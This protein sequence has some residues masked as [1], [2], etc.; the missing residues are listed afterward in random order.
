MTTVTNVSASNG[1]IKLTNN[2]SIEDA[3]SVFN[4]VKQELV[5]QIHAL[6]D[7][8]RKITKSENVDNSSKSRLRIAIESLL[9]DLNEE[10]FSLSQELANGYTKGEV[11]AIV[12]KAREYNHR[13]K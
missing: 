1:S 3:L 6:S 2:S 4:S 8:K 12:S 11:K 9:I 10:I 7:L 13:K 5:D